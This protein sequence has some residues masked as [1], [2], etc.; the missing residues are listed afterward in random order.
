MIKKKKETT[1]KDIVEVFLPKLWIMLLV[2]VLLAAMLS[3]YS[4][5]FKKDTYTSSSIVYVYNDKGGSNSVTNTDIQA[6]EE[7]VN[8]YNIA[9]TGDK[10]L[11]AVCVKPELTKY[12]LTPDAIKNMLTINQVDDNPVF[13]ISVTSLSPD[14]SYDVAA[15]ITNSIG[16]D[17]QENII[18]NALK[19]SVFEEPEIATS[20]NS[21]GTVR[22]ALIAFIA[23]FVISLVVVWVHASFDVVIRSTKK[24]EDTLDLPILGVIP[25][26]EINSVEE[27]N[28]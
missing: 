21:K 6:A 9:I 16:V 19:S 3:V 11:E 5:F 27:G 28:E 13:V 1:V 8:I 4:V 15:V 10:F 22:N 2:G 23:G 17:L 7:M 12:E 18:K 26:H 14:L 24:I 25:R 20:P